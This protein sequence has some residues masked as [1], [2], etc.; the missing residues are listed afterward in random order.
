MMYRVRYAGACL[1]MSL[2][3]LTPA[4][5]QLA[6][7]KF[8]KVREADF[9]QDWQREYPEADAVVLHDYGEIAFDLQSKVRIRYIVHQRLMILH[10]E[11]MKY[12]QARIPIPIE[13]N[14]KLKIAK[15]EA[16]TYRLNPAGKV[17]KANVEKRDMREVQAGD[18][19]WNLEF[20][21]PLAQVGSILEYTYTYYTDEI[22]H[23]SR[24][25]F[26]RDIPVVLS[27][28]H[29]FFPQNFR[30]FQLSTGDI[31]SVTIEK[32]R[33]Q[34][35]VATDY[36]FSRNN[37][38]TFGREAYGN[39]R[40]ITASGIHTIYVAEYMPPYELEPHIQAIRDYI[41]AVQFRL[42]GKGRS[43]KG[44]GKG[45]SPFVRSLFAGKTEES[46]GM[47]GLPQVPQQ[48]P[49]YQW[50]KI[51]GTSARQQKRDWE[52]IVRELLRHPDL[53]RQIDRYEELANRANRMAR[54]QREDE[55]KA[56]AI[57]EHVRRRMQWNGVY[58]LYADKLDQAYET[59]TGSGAAINL[60]LLNMLRGAGLNAYPVAIRTRNEGR[61][62]HLLPGTDY[63]N[64]L[65]VAVQLPDRIAML[66]ALSEVTAFGT[67]PENDLN[68]I[69]LLI[70]KDEWGW[71]QINPRDIF[72]RTCTSFNL[73]ESGTLSGTVE[74][75]H[76][77]F[78]AAVERARWLDDSISQE[79]YIN[80]FV[81]SGLEDK[82]ISDYR[83]RNLEATDEPFIINCNFSTSAFVEKVDNYLFVRPMTTRTISE[84][85]FPPAKRNFPISFPAPTRDYYLL[86]MKIPEGYEVAQMPSP[87]FV[88]LGK[89]GGQFMYNTFLDGEYLFITSAIYLAQ[90][91]FASEAYDDLTRFFE[92]VV[93]KHAEDIVLKRTEQ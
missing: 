89:E 73:D 93:D 31:S 29:T 11:G 42:S 48:V 76:T 32:E 5:A 56:H 26:Q 54:R 13:Q 58:S 10:E 15:I 8:Q 46:S 37:R 23:T 14:R 1:L 83:F 9:Q 34:Q 41:P 62:F 63:F 90:T 28:L 65:I 52:S 57:F 78:S 47:L 59:K 16:A 51:P 66:D 12:A 67:L 79:E 71:M 88:R 3:L 25:Q 49:G 4:L 7:P 39:T 2:A 33:Y 81:L 6:F 86:G 38:S 50:M 53:G 17:M 91:Y 69:G 80:L 74:V 18:N 60:I 92:F 43:F 24:W 61:I 21:F 36:F 64:H 44:E 72:S 20:K 22:R 27:E 77:E 35:P 19:N 55:K 85:P 87:L 84:N 70:D 82:H 68:E 30:Y 45:R 75:I 40:N